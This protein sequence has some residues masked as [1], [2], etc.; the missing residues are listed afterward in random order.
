MDQYV[1]VDGATRGT[2]PGMPTTVQSGG[3]LA[4][5]TN[6]GEYSRTVGAWIPEMTLNVGYRVSPNVVAF[7]GYNLLC[8]SDVVRPGR[9]IDPVVNPD[10]LPFTNP[11]GASQAFRPDITGRSDSF[12]AQGF[13]FGVAFN[14]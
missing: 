4:A 5:V 12:W 14:Y 8:I 7:I 6:I 11:T 1:N 10:V 9:Q 13:N 2:W 3:T